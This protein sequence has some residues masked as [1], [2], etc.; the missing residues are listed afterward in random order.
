MKNLI[1]RSITG[2]LFVAVLVGAI[3]GGPMTFAVLFALITGL[4]LWEFSNLMN[5][6][7]GA[8]MNRMIVT[9]AGVYLFSP[10]WLLQRADPV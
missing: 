9:V 5:R 1:M 2:V 10:F 3:V 4:S 6:H 8:G 7:Y